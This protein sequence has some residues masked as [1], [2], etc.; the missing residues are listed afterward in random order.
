MM[1]VDVLQAWVR[2]DDSR[3]DRHARICKYQRLSA[4][5]SSSVIGMM[6]PKR[7]RLWPLFG[8]CYELRHQWKPS[9]TSQWSASC[10]TITRIDTID[11]R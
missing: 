10:M 7:R 6:C 11:V 3:D 9:V 4:S 5:L 2:S 8:K 1:Q